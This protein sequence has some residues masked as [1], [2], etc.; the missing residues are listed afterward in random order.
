MRWWCD[1]RYTPTPPTLERD[2]HAHARTR[3]HAHVCARGSSVTLE[4]F[5]LW[6]NNLEAVTEEVTEDVTEGLPVTFS[7][8][9]NVTEDVTERARNVFRHL[10]PSRWSS[11]TS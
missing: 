1:F 9:F 8:T 6:A 2:T 3:T 10:S 5:P 7:V 11:V 4:G